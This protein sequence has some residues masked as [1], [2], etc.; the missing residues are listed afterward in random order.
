[1]KLYVHWI[2]PTSRSL[3]MFA[4]DNKPAV[5]QVVV[6]LFAGAHLE[7]PFISINPNGL[8]PVLTDGD[9]VLTESSS[10]LKYLAEKYELTSAYPK[11]LVQR[12]KVN[13]VIDWFNCNLYRD[14]GYGFV[15]PQVFP[16]HRRP[17]DVVNSGTVAWGKDRS[18]KWLKVLNDHIIGDGRNYLVGGTATIADYL[19]AEQLSI[20][21]LVGCK[22]ADFPNVRRWLVNMK[23]LPSWQTV[24][25]KYYAFCESIRSQPF[26]A[27]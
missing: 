3:S 16:N 4:E 22:F 15:Y 18:M 12:A 19:G 23:K 14:F 24:N 13:E 27:I 26:V 10:I 25:E 9:L 6:D 7:E 8:V 11:Q 21:K 5:E 17:N 20:G 2:S 1:M